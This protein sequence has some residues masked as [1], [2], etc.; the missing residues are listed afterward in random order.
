M[1]QEATLECTKKW[2]QQFRSRETPKFG[3][4]DKNESN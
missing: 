1:I 3:G 4:K 2:G